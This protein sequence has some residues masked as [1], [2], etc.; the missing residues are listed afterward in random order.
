[1]LS[2]LGSWTEERGKYAQRQGDAK[3]WE[4]IVYWSMQDAGL[5]CNCDAA[6]G[7]MPGSA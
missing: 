2:R 1:M 4:L 5:E 3:G 7:E 6:A